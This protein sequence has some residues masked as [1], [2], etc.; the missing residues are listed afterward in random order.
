M[1][2]YRIL[3]YSDCTARDAL[4]RFIAWCRVAKIEPYIIL[5]M[6]TGSLE[7]ALN[8]IEFC[9]GIGDTYWANLRRKHTGKDEPHAVR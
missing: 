2:I 1:F 7:D 5:N 6:G 8:W 9:N 3:L 4:N